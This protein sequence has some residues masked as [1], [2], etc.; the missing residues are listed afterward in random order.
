MWLILEELFATIVKYDLM[1]NL[2]KCVF[3][4]EAGK[5]LGFLLTEQGIE[6]NPDKN[7][8]DEEPC[9]CK[10]STIV[11]WANG[12]PVSILVSRSG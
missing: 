11:D 9:H 1:L 2:E 5:F 4:V 3:V 10:G 8:R 6:A 7:H 12:R